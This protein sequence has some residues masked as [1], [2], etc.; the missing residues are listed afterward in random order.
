MRGGAVPASGRRLY[1]HS[2]THKC[3]VATQCIDTPHRVNTQ[4]FRHHL[5]AWLAGT[6]KH[7]EKAWQL[8]EQR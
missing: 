6:N 1:G 4:S 5:G 7:D 3:S 2:S 8:P